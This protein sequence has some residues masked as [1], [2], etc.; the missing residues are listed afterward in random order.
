M[1]LA[2]IIS[3]ISA[4]LTLVLGYAAAGRWLMV[5]YVAAIGLLW[6]FGA[7]RRWSWLDSAAFV[8]LIIGAAFGIGLEVSIGWLLVG[9]VAALIAWDLD[10][11]LIRLARRDHSESAGSLGPGHLRRL[12]IVSSLGLLL[13]WISLGL[14][15]SLTFG[16]AI[17]LGLLL[18]LS[19]SWTFG[20]IRRA[21]G[22]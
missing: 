5:T 19:L 8:G 16:F 7:W 22:R 11:L 1:K 18:A 9:T 20:L 4:S 12:A 10:N 3:I 15:I 17:L 14:D 6:L 2:A 13:G 21:G